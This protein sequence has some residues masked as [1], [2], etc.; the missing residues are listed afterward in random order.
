MKRGKSVKA[1]TTVKPN[2]DLL[3]SEEKIAFY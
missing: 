2:E 1:V 3:E